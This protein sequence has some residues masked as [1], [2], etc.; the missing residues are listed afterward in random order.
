MEENLQ[1]IT[2]HASWVMIAFIIG[3][4]A[5]IF[6]EVIKLNKAA[7]A[8]LM[9][10]ACWTILFL[11]PAE[12]AERHLYI[13]TFQMFKVTQVLFFLLGALTIVE[14]INVHK[15][16]RIITESLQMQSKR[17]MLWA[18]GFVTFFLSSVLDNLTT[19]VVMVSLASKLI[20]DRL[21]RITLGG[22]I[23]IAANLGGTW[24]PI[25]DVA[26]T[27]LW[28]Y[29]RVSTIA[30]MRDLFLPSFIGMIATLFWF[31]RIFKG[32]FEKKDLDIEVEQSAP[33]STLVLILGIGS[34]IF[35]PIFKLLTDLPAFMAM[36]L[37]L[38][39][40]WIMT[41]LLHYKYKERN[42]L[43]V[44][45]I[46]PRV[47]IS[48]ILFYLGVILS[49]NAL[50]SAG[51]LTMMSNWL[52]QN[53]SYPIV[54][55][56]FIGLVSSVVD[57]VSLVAATMGMYNIQQFPIDSTF[58]QTI[59]YAAGTGGSLF[60][61]GSAAGVALM[62]LEKVNFMW[63]T[64]NI[65]IPALIAYIVGLIAYFLLSPLTKALF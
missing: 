33:G 40:M 5:V 42:Y 54:I 24:T 47:D 64:K 22:M 35:V 6:E 48:V 57:N 37:G 32:D 50:Q 1:E 52:N 34:L 31:N 4:T 15:G 58:W 49:I 16:F 36:M 7:T 44:T 62:A 18:T 14:I 43:R 26:T 39:L 12:S 60:I 41:D 61:I 11:E 20:E 25:G 53:V 19:T 9:A 28:I 21:E 63:Y 10:V 56:V 30:I 29:G 8:L 59:A 3:Y 27:L 13:F 45:S 65:T 23:V 46:L 17:K 38:S 55:P 51:L 2:T